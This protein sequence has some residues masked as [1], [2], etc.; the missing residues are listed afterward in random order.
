MELTIKEVFVD[1]TVNKLTNIIVIKIVYV[2]I[3]KLDHIQD[4]ILKEKR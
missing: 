2:A 4:K 1:K 3:R